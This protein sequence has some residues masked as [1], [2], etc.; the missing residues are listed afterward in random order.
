MDISSVVILVTLGIVF[1]TLELCIGVVLGWQLCARRIQTEGPS[2]DPRWSAEMIGIRQQMDQLALLADASRSE[3]PSELMQLIVQLATAIANLQRDMTAAHRSEAYRPPDHAAVGLP[4]KQ[5]P[6]PQPPRQDI[7]PEEPTP[8]AHASGTQDVGNTEF[9]EW[10]DRA[11]VPEPAMKLE[12]TRRYRFAV[13]QP[14]APFRDGNLDNYR[15]VQCH[16]ISRSEIRYVVEQQPTYSEAVI[17]IGVPAPVKLILVSIDDYRPVYM[18][19]LVGFLVTATFRKVIPIDRDQPEAL[20][21]TSGDE[22]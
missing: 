2:P 9:I 5:P 15:D 17:G 10:F 3:L 20:V 21:A 22:N 4:R 8:A 18:Y 1:G 16:D 7:K 6:S 14:L 12:G 13:S 19:G 11:G